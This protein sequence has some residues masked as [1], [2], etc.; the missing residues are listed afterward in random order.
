MHPA[1][2][3]V[4]TLSLAANG[5]GDA[6]AA[7]VAEMLA[8]NATLAALDIRQKGRARAAPAM[9]GPQPAPEPEPESQLEPNWG[10]ILP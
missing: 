9:A 10:P 3:S 4:T 1:N 2:R 8:T 6:G 7:A 5:M